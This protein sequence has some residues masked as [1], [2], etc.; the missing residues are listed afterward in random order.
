MAAAHF[1]SARR[2]VAMLL[3]FAGVWSVSI[4]VAGRTSRVRQQAIA[5]ELAG[6]TL[7][8]LGVR[9]RVR[10]AVP[11]TAPVLMVA[12]HVSWLDVYAVNCLL[13]ARFVAK[14]EV[15]AWPFVGR[16]V[17]AFGALFIRRGCPRDA[18]RVRDRIRA[19]LQ[20]GDRVVFFPEGTTTDGTILRRFYPA[21]FQGAVDTGAVVQAVAIRYVDDDGQPTDAA[22]FIDDMTFMHSLRRIVAAER[23]TIELHFGPIIAAAGHTR[24]E[25]AS[26]CQTWIAGRLGVPAPA[27]ATRIP[28]HRFDRAA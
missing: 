25:L 14:T 28:R 7:R 11:K 23:I 16:M 18:A 2:L 1:R 19:A 9:V 10:G 27:E 24:R 13:R 15:R 20:Q 6:Q 21:L 8:I 22:A 12:N 4:L 5:R 26:T 17:A 3:H